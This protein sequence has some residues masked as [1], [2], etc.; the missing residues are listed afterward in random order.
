MDVAGNLHEDWRSFNANLVSTGELSE[1]TSPIRT[2]GLS[3]IGELS[4]STS[5]IRTTGIAN[6]G[7]ILL[8][9]ML[10]V[11]RFPGR[12]PR[13]EADAGCARGKFGE[14]GKFTL[15]IPSYNRPHKSPPAKL[16]LQNIG[17]TRYA[18]AFIRSGLGELA[19]IVNHCSI[20]ANRA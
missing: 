8:N 15:D 10:E 4:E 2:T 18:A 9:W 5:P 19:F 14:Q 6:I 17:L 13:L 11:V 7:T 16:R 1:S 3:I 20:V 12:Q